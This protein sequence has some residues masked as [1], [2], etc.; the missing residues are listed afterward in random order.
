[1]KAVTYL[2]KFSANATCHRLYDVDY[3]F[4]DMATNGTDRFAL[5]LFSFLEK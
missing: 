4:M 5:L 2:N 1:M 3:Y